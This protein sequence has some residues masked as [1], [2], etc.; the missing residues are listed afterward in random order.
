MVLPLADESKPKCYLCYERFD[1]I[2]DLREHQ[3]TKHS[4][5]ESHEKTKKS[6]PGDVTIF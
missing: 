4:D 3:K 5:I 1:N 6:A 2:D